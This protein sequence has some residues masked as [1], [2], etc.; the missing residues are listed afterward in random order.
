MPTVA[1]VIPLRDALADLRPGEPLRHGPLTVI[2]LT[3]GP[4]PEPD[5]LTL[6]EAGEAVII[7]EVSQAGAVPTLAV[8]NTADRPV[9]LLDGE[10][11][12]GAKQNRVL[13]TSVLIAKGRAPGHPRVVR[14][15]GPLG[16]QERAL[17][18][19]RRDALRQR[20]RQE[21]ARQREPAR[22]RPAQRPGRGVKS[23]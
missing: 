9:L 10:E 2:P 18:L 13:N 19:R 7:E 8:T 3:G 6:A 15:A 1:E 5:W 22:R 4:T 11:L 17:V 12:V 21:G 23:P 20:P 16:V 14:R